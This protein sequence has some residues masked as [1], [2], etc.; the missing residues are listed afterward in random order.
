MKLPPDTCPVYN[1]IDLRAEVGAISRGYPL[2]TCPVY[3]HIDLRRSLH[4]P[5]GSLTPGC[6]PEPR[7]RIEARQD[8]EE[9][10][11]MA[12]YMS[13]AFLLFTLLT[14]AAALLGWI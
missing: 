4:L 13:I 9:Y 11:R 14:Y 3:N 1:H 12:R 5:H 7:W 6:H 10:R 2:D 8:A